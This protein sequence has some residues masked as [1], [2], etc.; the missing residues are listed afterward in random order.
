MKGR[1]GRDRIDLR[2][3]VFWKPGTDVTPWPST[4]A[5]VTGASSGRSG[6]QGSALKQQP[7]GRAYG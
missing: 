5:T 3:K 7:I 2:S 4:T 1:D 6:Q